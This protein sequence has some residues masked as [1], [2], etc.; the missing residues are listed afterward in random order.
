MATLAWCALLSCGANKPNC[1][2]LC[3]SSIDL[4]LENAQGVA[5]EPGFGSITFDGK[6]EAFDCRATA[7]GGRP[8]AGIA[9]QLGCGTTGLFLSGF[10]GGPGELT[11]DVTEAGGSA[12]FSG[13]VPLV[14]TPRLVCGSSCLTA[15]TKVTLR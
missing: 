14:Y 12:M 10:S 6:T 8:D 4:A 7:T 2:A 15:S 5:V 13:V 9:A 1:L 11:L 3:S